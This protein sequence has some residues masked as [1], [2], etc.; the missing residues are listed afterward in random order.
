[1]KSVLLLMLGAMFASST[2]TD[3]VEYLEPLLAANRDAYLAGPHTPDRQAAA[4]AYFDQQWRWLKSSQGCGSKLLGAAGVACL[5]DRSRTGKWPW[6]YYYR[7]PIAA[8]HL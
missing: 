3:Y 4:L 8:G 5:A 7:D 2:A 1:M 6:E